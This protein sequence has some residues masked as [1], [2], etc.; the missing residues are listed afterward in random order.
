MLDM[1]VK[2]DYTK[3]RQLAFKFRDEDSI[4]KIIKGEELSGTL[5]S[6]FDLGTMYEDKN[7]FISILFYMGMLTIKKAILTNYTFSVPNYVIKTIYWDYFLD[8]LRS[9]L[10]VGYS[11]E[12]LRNAITTMALE[13]KIDSFIDCLKNILTGLSNRDLINFDEKYIKAVMMSLI[14]IPGIYLIISEQE[15]TYGY[16]DLILK[17]GVQFKDQIKFEYIFEIKY[18]KESSS[19][20]EFE[21][22]RCEAIAQ[23]DK[24]LKSG[25]MESDGLIKVIIIVKGK[26]AVYFELI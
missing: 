18:L 12:N 13:G 11:F 5:V 7:N 8:A 21:N 3:I 22:K 24:Y 20:N 9:K 25:C 10:D 26:N 6:R 2:T 1:N 14:N 15:V 17:K 16:V 4:E 23:M 19:E